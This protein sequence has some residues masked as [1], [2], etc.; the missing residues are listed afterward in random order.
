ME[1]ADALQAVIAAYRTR[2]DEILPA[3][4]LSPAVTQVARV[5][6]LV[7][8]A[9]AY[10]YLEAT[11][12]LARFRRDLRAAEDPPGTT[13]GIEAYERW[14]ESVGPAVERLVTTELLWLLVATL[15]A[16]VVVF[17]LLY[18]LARGA[19]LAGCWAAMT[20]G[21]ASVAA[22]A[23][24]RRYWRPLLGLVLL[25]AVV[26]T[27]LTAAVVAPVA[28]LARESAAAAVAVA[29]LLGFLWLVAVVV[30]RLVVAFAGVAIVVDD[31]G[32]RAGLAG[33][34]GFIRANPLW[35]VGYSL[36]VLGV[37][38]LVGSAAAA[39]G[40]GSGAASGL[41]GFVL[42][43][44][45]L[46][47]LKTALYGDHAAAV[48]PPTATDRSAVTQVRGGLARGWRTMKAF[49][50]GHPGLHL[51][52]AALMVAGGV[53]GWLLAGPYEGLL[54]TSIEGRLA[55]HSPRTAVVTFTT[56][57]VAVA[58]SSAFSGLALGVP[59]AA[60]LLFNGGLLG[61]LARLEVAPL[62]LV[63]F[64]VPHGVVELPA[65]VIAGALGFSLG[66]DAWR[67][68]RGRLDR[69][70]LADALERAFWVLVG[71]AMLLAVAGLIEGVLSPYYYRPFLG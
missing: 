18:P 8:L 71:V 55:T 14:F 41:L 35:V 3:Y 46:D 25:Q 12:R 34:G 21:R 58:I 9:V 10:A 39:G 56:N 68:V 20:D 7:G 60:A 15:L 6:A 5:V 64:V 33:A 22:L 51:L 32:L 45:T 40:P 37:Y 69:A 36:A 26:L 23:G 13:A 11:G 65:L 4:F 61:A 54:T 19:Q 16:A 38:A 27:V 67:A 63:A 52:A 59:T 42:V 28:V 43:S 30:L 31:A 24:A 29:L 57:N 1:F 50:A 47:L 62:V 66:G 70:G 17:T 53:G 49:V 44:P 2:T 48:D